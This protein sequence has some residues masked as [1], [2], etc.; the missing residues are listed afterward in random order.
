MGVLYVVEGVAIVDDAAGVV[1]D[2]TVVD[3]D[4]VVFD[5]TAGVVIDDA[6]EE[7][8]AL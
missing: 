5:D 4:A 2:F 3:N 1:I 6:A 8:E 7:E